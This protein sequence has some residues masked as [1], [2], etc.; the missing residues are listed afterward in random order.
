MFLTSMVIH[1]GVYNEKVSCH[2]MALAR[3]YI[4]FGLVVL[5]ILA[6]IFLIGRVSK[7][8]PAI[9]T[10][11]VG[12]SSSTSDTGIPGPPGP[13]GVPGRLGT[14]GPK[15]DN[16][17]QGNTGPM[18]PAGTVGP[19]GPAGKTGVQGVVG[20]VGPPGP[21]G[22]PGSVGPAGPSIPGPPGPAGPPGTAGP[23]G[24]SR[25][26][27]ST[28]GSVLPAEK[29]QFRKILKRGET[30]LEE[31]AVESPNGQY[32]ITVFSMFGYLQVYKKGNPAVA[33]WNSWPLYNGKYGVPFNSGRPGPPNRLSFNT[34]G[35]L[36]FGTV[37][38]EDVS[39]F[40]TQDG[41]TGGTDDG[42][43]TAGVNNYGRF[44]VA[45]KN[46]QVI[47]YSGSKDGEFV[48]GVTGKSPEQIM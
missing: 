15:G 18:G 4:I 5:S 8:K 26:S 27:S 32:F 1:Y 29:A 38:G 6:I 23:G 19:A 42:G 24:P 22:P 14:P 47:G 16:G 46:N 9:I 48:K 39:C 43:W 3:K 30:L 17:P 31:N 28:D 35:N 37:G 25:P 10:V 34:D 44:Y 36:C 11:G 41:W 2:K 33:I 20:P 45:D 40:F 12:S 13:P 21:I 7:P